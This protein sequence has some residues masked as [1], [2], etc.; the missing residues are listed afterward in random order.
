MLAR[1]SRE[2]SQ[3]VLKLFAW[4]ALA[5]RK[6]SKTGTFGPPSPSV[7][8]MY[9]DFNDP[10]GRLST[11][12]LKGSAGARFRYD[13]TSLYHLWRLINALIYRFMK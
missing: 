12:L 13:S 11:L 2:S 4:T 9:C 6:I 1:S 8:K 10:L 5:H 3:G 7:C